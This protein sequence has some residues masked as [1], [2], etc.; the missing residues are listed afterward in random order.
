MTE[1]HW[2]V[3]P[4]DA[5]EWVTYDA[6]QAE[7]L[8]ADPNCEVRGP[9][10]LADG[11]VSLSTVRNCLIAAR[12]TSAPNDEVAAD[13]AIETLGLNNR[14]RRAAIELANASQTNPEKPTPQAD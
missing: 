1:V 12:L 11:G 5:T 13:L 9:F 4:N 7:R 14:V 2:L 3:V 6:E 8:H 10:V